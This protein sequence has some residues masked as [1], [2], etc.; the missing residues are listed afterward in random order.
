MAEKKVRLGDTLGLI[1]LYGTGNG[2]MEM[3][4]E[5]GVVVDIISFWGTV[6][7]T[8][9]TGLLSTSQDTL[10]PF[11]GSPKSLIF[12]CLPPKSLKSLKSSRFPRQTSSLYHHGT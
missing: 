3:T 4:V 1:H 7:G 11:E 2:G 12:L 10:D 6:R 8:P 5:R 9:L